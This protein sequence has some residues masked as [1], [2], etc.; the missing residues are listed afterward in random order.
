V[1]AAGTVPPTPIERKIVD[2]TVMPIPSRLWWRRR[3]LNPR[4][5][6]MIPK[7]LHA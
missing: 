6:K 4:P 3:E 2:R 5:K 7:S 1:K